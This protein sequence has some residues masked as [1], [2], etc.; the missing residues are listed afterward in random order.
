M[1]PRNS[2]YLTLVVALL[3]GSMFAV[4]ADAQKIESS[5][6]TARVTVR[7]VMVD[8]NVVSAEVVNNS[9]YTVRDVELL[10]QY[11]WLWKNEFKPGADS[12]GRV[13]SVPLQ[14]EL[15]PGESTPFTYTPQPSLPSRTDGQFMVEVTVAS[16]A[17]VIPQKSADAAGR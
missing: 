8:N 10:L 16:F 12:P 5:P 9:A 6:Q 11:H 13:V 1:K 3:C 4:A 7:N 2:L 17:E 14:K 15:R